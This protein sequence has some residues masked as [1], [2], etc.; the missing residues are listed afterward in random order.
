MLPSVLPSVHPPSILERSTVCV[1]LVAW[2][3]NQEPFKIMISQITRTRSWSVHL[4][5]QK[6]TILS[7]AKGGFWEFCQMPRVGFHVRDQPDDYHSS[8][9]EHVVRKE[10]PFQ[11]QERVSCARLNPSANGIHSPHSVKMPEGDYHGELLGPYHPGKQIT[12]PLDLF[13]ALKFLIFPC[14][15]S[16]AHL[17]IAPR[18]ILR[19]ERS[20]QGSDGPRPHHST[21]RTR[22]WFRGLLWFSC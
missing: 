11:S 22:R 13:F 9:G 2:T 7:L 12:A 16:I 20:S 4:R 6:G 21:E 1:T 5:R 10:I 14:H 3:V 18:P 17:S 8:L 19:P 15:L